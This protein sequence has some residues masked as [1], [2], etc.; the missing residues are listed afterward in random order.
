MAQLL[1]DAPAVRQELAVSAPHS[2]ALTPGHV[3]RN[4]RYQA[5]MAMLAEGSSSTYF[6]DEEM[7]DR[8]PALFHS[9][10]GRYVTDA[11]ASLPVPA[12]ALTAMFE[13][14]AR[15]Q[16]MRIARESD[17]KHGDDASDDGAA[18]AEAEQTGAGGGGGAVEDRR[19]E[20]LAAMQERFLRGEDSDFFNY[21]DVDNDERLDV[22]RE[23]EQDAEDRYFED[24]PPSAGART[25][26][27]MEDARSTAHAHGTHR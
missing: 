13:S 12:M 14:A 18:G 25:S 1:A 3:V 26:T 10:Y 27:H 21:A 23:A 9:A 17:G 11:R 2:A 24:T 4:R 8:A 7:E 6:S 5:M 19:R 22:C 20:L 16:D 15:T